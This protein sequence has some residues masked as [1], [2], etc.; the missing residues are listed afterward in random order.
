MWNRRKRVIVALGV[1]VLAVCT[2]YGSGSAAGARPRGAP[3]ASADT[4]L[5]GCTGGFSGGGGGILVTTAGEIVSWTQA[6]FAAKRDYHLLRVDTAAAGGVFRELA[7]IRF[8]TI[9]Y[10]KPDNMTCS[11]ELTGPGGHHSVDWP[12]DRP[13]ASVRAIYDRVNALGRKGS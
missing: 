11:L 10:S 2:G 7:R 5:S 13:P 6:T 9:N 3:G 8:R 4:V 1:T 12:I